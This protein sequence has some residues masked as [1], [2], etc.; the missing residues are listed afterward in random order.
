MIAQI[1]TI[2]AGIKTLNEVSA[3]VRQEMALSKWCAKHNIIYKTKIA[4]GSK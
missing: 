3:E 1:V 2:I 4:R